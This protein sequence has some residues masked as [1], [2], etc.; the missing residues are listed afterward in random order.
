MWWNSIKNLKN[1]YALYSIS[2]NLYVWQ[3]IIFRYIS[4]VST[5][6]LDIPFLKKM[7]RLKCQITL[8][9]LF[10]KMYERVIYSRL[11]F[12]IHSK[13]ILVQEQYRFRTSSLTELAA[14]KL[15]NFLTTHD[16]KLLVGGLF[17]YLTKKH[18]T[19][20][21]LIYYLQNLSIMVLMRRQVIWWNPI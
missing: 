8:L 20:W 6:F 1:K 9:A 7:T 12:H 18:L 14:Y 4:Y 19:V 10:S 11:Q 15:N 3:G 17:Y 21:N 5:I 16:N 2:S 13:N